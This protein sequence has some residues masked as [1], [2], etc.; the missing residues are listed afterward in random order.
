MVEM[1]VAMMLGAGGGGGSAV[2]EVVALVAVVA[3]AIKETVLATRLAPM[4][5]EE[6]P[7][8]LLSSS[9]EYLRL[10]LSK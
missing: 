4:I 1:V 9:K 10:P 2:V 5:H 8:H 6:K 7:Q 3:L